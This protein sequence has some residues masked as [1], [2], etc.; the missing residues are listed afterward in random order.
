MSTIAAAPFDDTAADVILQSSDNVHFYVYK[1]VL[2]LASPVFADMFAVP[3]PQRNNHHPHPV[4]PVSESSR[5]LGRLLAWCDPRCTPSFGSPENIP[6]MLK[7]ADKYGMDKMT[8]HAAE[9]LMLSTA[10]IEREP[11]RVFA[12]SVRYHLTDVAKMAAKA[13]LCY[14]WEEQVD[15]TT[16]E[17]KD[18]PAISLRQLDAYQLAC[19]PPPFFQ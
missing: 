18:I 4:I 15:Q 13:T 12:I 9:I 14:S 10:Y 2:A 5:A 19:Q 1:I 16:P 11:M 3:Q 6:A 8:R 17:L 7:V